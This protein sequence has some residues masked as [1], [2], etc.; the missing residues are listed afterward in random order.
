MTSI[1]G[2]SIKRACK[3]IAVVFSF[4]I[5]MAKRSNESECWLYFEKS[6]AGKAKC[7]LCDKSLACVGGSTSGLMAHVRAVHPESV[8]SSPCRQ[9]R[10]L[11]AFGV[12]PHRPCSDSRQE[13]ITGLISELIVANMLPVSLVE[14]P[15]FRALL[16]F[17]EP[18]Y[19][20]PCRQTMTTRLDTMAAKRR[21]ELQ[22]E[23]Q[24]DAS[25]IAVTTDIWTSLANDPYISLTAT[26][27]TPSWTIRTPTLANTLMDERHTQNN[28]TAR[29]ADITADWEVAQKVVAVVHDGA[30]NMRECGSRN[31][32]MDVD[33]SAHKIHLCVTSAM[34]IDKV[35]DANFNFSYFL[36]LVR[37]Q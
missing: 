36:A 15:E 31:G 6:V 34:G 12:G 28:I 27:I 19:K 24:S 3:I 29:L 20:T 13:Q 30:A 11:G 32:W 22:N 5:T 18:A 10:T 26:Y 35:S 14:S 7:K 16:A 1:R 17:L 33:C 9:Q 21:C 37:L 4:S 8:K 23:L 2:I 25:A